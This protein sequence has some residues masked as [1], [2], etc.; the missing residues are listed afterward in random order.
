[1]PARFVGLQPQNPQIPGSHRCNTKGEKSPPVPRSACFPCSSQLS[2]RPANPYL[3]RKPLRRSSQPP[4]AQTRRQRCCC[5]PSSVQQQASI[6]SCNS[7]LSLEMIDIHT[8]AHS[9]NPYRRHSG[10]MK[11]PTQM[12]QTLRIGQACMFATQLIT[13]VDNSAYAHTCL[14]FC[15]SWRDNIDPNMVCAW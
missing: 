10:K 2:P 15:R 6:R 1:M 7:L 14:W 8:N 13:A 4:H 12:K 3:C 11:D 5:Q 9:S